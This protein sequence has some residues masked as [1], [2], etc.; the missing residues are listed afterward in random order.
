MVDLVGLQAIDQVGNVA[1]IGQV[2]IVDEERDV[3]SVW[4][5]VQMTHPMC[6]KGAGLPDDAMDLIALGEQEL[7]EVGSILSCDACY[8]RFFHAFS[9]F[10]LI[11]G[12]AGPQANVMS[13]AVP[14][15]LDRNLNPT[16]E[17][18]ELLSVHERKVSGSGIELCEGRNH[19]IRIAP[20]KDL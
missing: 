6:I 12:L 16:A 2:S 8:Q 18:P 4:V 20:C 7:S 13:S 9:L 11:A 3:T 1:G 5:N 14:V 19:T 15:A 17:L 10:Y